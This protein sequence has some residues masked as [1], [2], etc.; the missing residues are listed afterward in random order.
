MLPTSFNTLSDTLKDMFASQRTSGNKEEELRKAV[1]REKTATKEILSH[2]RANTNG[3]TKEMK[4]LIREVAELRTGGQSKDPGAVTGQSGSLLAAIGNGF[5]NQIGL[6]LE[7][8]T[9]CSHAI[10]EAVEKGVN[11]EKSLKRKRE[12]EQNYTFRTYFSQPFW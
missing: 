10:Q 9:R 7:G 12:E 1:V 5:E 2:V 4:N 8:I 6:L 11:P 3:H